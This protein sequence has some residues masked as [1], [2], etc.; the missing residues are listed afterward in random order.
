MI[1]KLTLLLFLFTFPLIGQQ[2]QLE[3]KTPTGIRAYYFGD[4]DGDGIGEFLVMDSMYVVSV[5]DGLSHNLKWSINLDYS[6]WIMVRYGYGDEGIYFPRTPLLDFNGNGVKDFIIG[7]KIIDPSTNT[8]IFDFSNPNGFP[9]VLG[10]DD[11][12][13]DNQLE[14]LISDDDSTIYVYSTGISVSSIESNNR[15]KGNNYKLSQNFPN[16][17][18]PTTAIEY[19]I[20]TRSRATIRIYNSL[21]QLIRTLLDEDKTPGIYISHWDSR[22]DDGAIVATGAY[23]YQL[24][25]GE[26]VSSKNM[27]LIK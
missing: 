21:G 6:N 11:V 24:Q 19:E 14:L 25:V 5:Y 10:L 12:D 15:H 7:D 27:L 4:L 22:D 20:Q 26:F 9:D 17:F 18:N 8:L 16:P 23:Y 1:K 13:N 2:F 3:W